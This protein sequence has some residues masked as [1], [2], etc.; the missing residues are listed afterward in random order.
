LLNHEFDDHERRKGIA[1]GP[2]NQR[3]FGERTAS[4]WWQ[5]PAGAALT[6]FDRLNYL[7]QDKIDVTAKFET[8]GPALPR[9]EPVF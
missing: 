1:N 5:S 2:R 3:S 8:C 9:F 6:I 4:L 7:N